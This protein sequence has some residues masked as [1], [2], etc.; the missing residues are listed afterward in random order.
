M[1]GGDK[2]GTWNGGGTGSTGR[3]EGAMGGGNWEHWEPY[4]EPYW[5]DWEPLPPPRDLKG[6]DCL[7]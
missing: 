6:M 2:E 5:E 3:G 4:W 1:G 7:N